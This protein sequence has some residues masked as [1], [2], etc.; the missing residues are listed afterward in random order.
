MFY[1]GIPGINDESASKR[2][3]VYRPSGKLLP[4]ARSIGTGPYDETEIIDTAM[5]MCYPGLF[6]RTAASKILSQCR[7]E[8][9]QITMYTPEETELMLRSDGNQYIATRDWQ[10][11]KYRQEL[12]RPEGIS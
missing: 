7:S 9:H 10:G 12:S 2:L 8:G 1:P 11:F 6:P 5:T 4:L 3:K